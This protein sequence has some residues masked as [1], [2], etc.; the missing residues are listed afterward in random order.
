MPDATSPPTILIADDESHIVYIL[1]TKLSK[2]GY[3]VV[4]ARNGAQALELALRESPALC[5]TDLN[6][7]GT[8]GL[9]FSLGLCQHPGTAQTPVIMLTGRG[10]TVSEDQRALTNIVHLESKPFSARH[11]LVLVESILHPAAA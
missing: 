9:Q 2:A 11:L 3:R 10:H 1:E 8:D 6:M 7:P 5:I 4:V